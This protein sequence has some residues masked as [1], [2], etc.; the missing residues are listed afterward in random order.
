MNKISIIIVSWNAREFL[1]SCLE[2]I[3][4][5]SRPIVGEIIVVDNASADGSPDMV[6]QEFPEVSLVRSKENLGFARANNLA[7][8]RATSDYW[9][10]VN[11]DVVV[12]PG[13]FEALVE[14]L[15][16]H[17]EAGLI[18]PKILGADGQLQW[19]CRRF[20]TFWNTLCRTLALDGP[21]GRSPLFSGREMR[22]WNH[23]GL[24]E[25]EVLSGCFWLARRTAV[26]QVGGLDERFFFYAED[27]DWC[28]RFRAAGWKVVFVPS[29]KA[30][31]YGGASSSN[32]PL[33]FSVE[34]LRANLIYWKK[35]Y[36]WLGQ[37]AF[38]LLSLA[39]YAIRLVVYGV[40]RMVGADSENQYKFTRSVVGVHWLLTGRIPA[41]H[42]ENVSSSTGSS[43]PAN[44]IDKTISA[45]PVTVEGRRH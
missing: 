33:R 22:H 36:G 6:A 32:A 41:K 28:K 27:V 43:V 14:F 9:A 7:M 11:S 31:H 26:D 12:H 2:S 37:A 4:A 38:Y 42:R 15:A 18:G 19:T 5:A 3:R 24:M 30:T 44:G 20:P 25:V 10:L 21:L 35:H 23:E 34:M 13:C 45:I 8:S 40:K 39:Y 16:R 1:R 17:P 29:A